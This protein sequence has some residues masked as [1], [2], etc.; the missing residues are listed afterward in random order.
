M[1]TRTILPGAASII[2]LTATIGFVD[3][4]REFEV[5]NFCREKI[6]L[7]GMPNSSENSAARSAMITSDAQENIAYLVEFKRGDKASRVLIDAATGK[8]IPS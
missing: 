1:K 6:S 4:Q 5:E 8:V 7:V 2:A 3:G